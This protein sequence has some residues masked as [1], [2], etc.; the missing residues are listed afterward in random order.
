MVKSLIELRP[1]LE[2]K[3]IVSS[4]S[5]FNTDEVTLSRALRLRAILP[6][7]LSSSRL[8]CRS[9]SRLATLWPSAMTA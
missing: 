6:L 3:V 2:Y 7:R 4:D 1:K 5:T 8:A 9:E